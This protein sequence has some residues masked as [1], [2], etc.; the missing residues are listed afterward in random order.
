VAKAGM[1]V[2]QRLI[3]C[4]AFFRAIAGSG[5]G[6]VGAGALPTGRGAING[7][8]DLVPFPTLASVRQLYH[9]DPELSIINTLLAIL[10]LSEMRLERT[11]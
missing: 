9:F 4:V 7:V 11:Q 2:H 3:S 8:V 10:R 6:T 5:A 1:P